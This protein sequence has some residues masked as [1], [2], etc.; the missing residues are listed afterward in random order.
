MNGRQ[1]GPRPA[2]SARIIHYKMGLMVN[3]RRLVKVS[4][5]NFL[6]KLQ[7]RKRPYFVQVQGVK[8]TICP[9][10]FPPRTDTRLLVSHVSIKKNTRILDLGTG[11]GAIAMIAGLRGATGIA[12]DINPRAVE[13]AQKN[14]DKYGLDIKALVSDT[15]D[16]IPKEKFDYIFATGPYLD[17]TINKPIMHAIY[18]MKRF[19]SSLL[20]EGPGY[21]KEKGEILATFPEWSDVNYFESLLIKNKLQFQVIGKKITSDKQ[22]IYRLYRI[23]SKT[24][25]VE[26]S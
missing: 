2:R 4:Q 23:K 20:S 5:K 3:E 9:G 11:S 1:R 24:S 16:K 21:L 8:I 10:V 13:N 14:F 22:R 25:G 12:I 7:K 15:F 19:V 6:N 18:G 17:G 26:R